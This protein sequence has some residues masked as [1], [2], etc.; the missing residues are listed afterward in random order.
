M[1][2][3][4]EL[5]E[6]FDQLSDNDKFRI[7][8]RFVLKLPTSHIARLENK[9]TNTITMCFQKVEAKLLKAK[10]HDEIVSAIQAM[11]CDLG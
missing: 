4:E 1:N 6:L 2:H 11:F 5:L 7:I 3:Y 9:K 8:C 10:T